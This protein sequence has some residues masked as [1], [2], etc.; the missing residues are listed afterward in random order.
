MKKLV[1]LVLL[2]NITAF[3]SFAERIPSIKYYSK[4]NSIKSEDYSDHVSSDDDADEYDYEYEYIDDEPEDAEYVY[5]DEDSGEHDD[6]DEY[7]YEYIYEEYEDEDPDE[8]SNKNDIDA[9]D[10]EEKATFYPPH[11]EMPPQQYQIYENADT[12]ADP[13]KVDAF[14]KNLKLQIAAGTSTYSNR[15][16][17]KNYTSKPKRSPV[18]SVGLNKQIDN[19]Y[20]LG[21]RLI[22]QIY[23]NATGSYT[24]IG[25]PPIT[26]VNVSSKFSSTSMLASGKYLIHEYH[27][28]TPYITG[29]LGVAVNTLK[30]THSEP[31]SG[32]FKYEN[33]F[34]L[35]PA[36]GLGLGLKYDFT[37]SNN[38]FLEYQYLNSGKLKSKNA[39]IGNVYSSDSLKYKLN[40]HLLMFG[41]E[42]PLQKKGK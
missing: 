19:K 3:V 25:S 6:S 13:K 12:T 24:S 17:E 14:R 4:K 16:K 5:E 42:I 21:L 36:F 11:R 35:Q 38:I 2:I 29:S 20:E 18:F 9:D 8:N 34:S 30:E 10:N 22:S 31:V 15:F 7:E 27:G 33:K 32:A 37:K 40:Q 26:T 39:V 41:I 28:F 1:F 23:S